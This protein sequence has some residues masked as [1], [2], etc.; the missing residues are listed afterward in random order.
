MCLYVWG[1]DAH[2]DCLCEDEYVGCMG[3]W[4]LCV[5][6]CMR[7]EYDDNIYVF[8]SECVCSVYDEYLRKC[9]HLCIYSV[10]VSVSGCGCRW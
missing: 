10:Y 8:V 1:V 7:G 5:C 4:I 3:S 6:V 9:V 2:G